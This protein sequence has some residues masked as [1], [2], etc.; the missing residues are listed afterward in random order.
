M[1]KKITVWKVTRR[2]YSMSVTAKGLRRRYPTGVTV[3][4]MPGMGPLMAFKSKEIA[5]AFIYSSDG[6]YKV[7]K[8]EAVKSEIHIVFLADCLGDPEGLRR[9]W[10]WRKGNRGLGG[11]WFTVPGTIFCEEI[12]CLE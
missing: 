5:K 3:K 11:V 7:R 9:F 2:G 4:P 8:A 6:F 10:K 12:T 1:S